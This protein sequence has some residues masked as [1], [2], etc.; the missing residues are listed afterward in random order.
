MKYYVASGDESVIINADCPNTAA[1]SAVKA[2][3]GEGRQARPLGAIISVSE[4][5]FEI[6]D[7]TIFLSTTRV[8]E[9]AGFEFRDTASDG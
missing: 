2:W 1:V 9:D 3:W 7:D 8:L 4:V 6:D 5:G